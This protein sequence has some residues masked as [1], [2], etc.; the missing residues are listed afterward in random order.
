[1][2]CKSECL[3]ANSDAC[4]SM[5]VKRG[6]L[7]FIIRIQGSP[8]L[9]VIYLTCPKGTKQGEREKESKGSTDGNKEIVKPTRDRIGEMRK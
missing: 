2:L 7:G 9:P 4:A 3:S 8:L 1:M 6:M 5:L